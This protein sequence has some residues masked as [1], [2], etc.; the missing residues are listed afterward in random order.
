MSENDNIPDILL[1]NKSWGSCKFSFERLKEISICLSNLNI[2]IKLPIF[3]IL[4]QQEDLQKPFSRYKSILLNCILDCIRLALPIST[5]FFENV[6]LKNVFNSPNKHKSNLKQSN[7]EIISEI[8][9][10]GLIE[11]IKT[12]LEK[13]KTI[14]SKINS[15]N[16]S[17]SKYIYSIE[18]ATEKNS[19][20]LIF[21]IE[22]I[23]ESIRK[24]QFLLIFT[25]L[26]DLFENSVIQ[27][28]I[29][30]IN[31]CK[32][33]ISS[34]LSY[35][36]TI[37]IKNELTLNF[38]LK[39]I[40]LFQSSKTT[41]I[42]DF[43]PHISGIL[44][45][46]GVSGISYITNTILTESIRFLRYKT[47]FSFDSK[48]L[49]GKGNDWWRDDSVLVPDLLRKSRYE[50]VKDIQ[51]II[52]DV[53]HLL[54]S[55]NEEYI[56]SVISQM[57]CE[58]QE[59]DDMLR[60]ETVKMVTKFIL[61]DIKS[62]YDT[63][64][65]G[66][67]IEHQ[68]NTEKES[69]LKNQLIEF[70]LS[71]SN[72]REDDIR[73]EVLEG[74][75]EAVNIF[76]EKSEFGYSCEKYIKFI[77]QQ[78]N[79]TCPNIRENMIKAVSVWLKNK[80]KQP[81]S[82]KL[83]D[84][85]IQYLLRHICDRNRN[86]RIYLIKHL[87]GYNEI[88]ELSR[89]LWLLWYVSFKQRDLQM[90]IIIEDILIEIN[91]LEAL[92]LYSPIKKTSETLYGVEKAE[93]KS[94]AT[95]YKIIKTFNYQR[96]TLLKSFRLFFCLLFL[97]QFHKNNNL[98]KYLESLKLEITTQIEHFFIENDK[99]SKNN[100][101]L[102]AKNM[103]TQIQ[104]SLISKDC[105]IKWAIILGMNI[106]NK[107]SQIENQSI[108]ESLIENVGL[109]QVEEF[110]KIIRYLSI[111]KFN[112]ENVNCK[113]LCTIFSPNFEITKDKLL[114]EDYTES[115]V[116]GLVTLILRLQFKYK[117]NLVNYILSN[118]ELNNLSGEEIVK[119][120]NGAINIFNQQ[121]IFKVYENFYFSSKNIFRKKLTR[122]LREINSMSDEMNEVFN[123]SSANNCFICDN[124]QG[125]HFIAEVIPENEMKI[126]VKDTIY[127]IFPKISISSIFC[128]YSDFQT[129]LDSNISRKKYKH[130]NTEKNWEIFI[131]RLQAEKIA[132]YE[133]LETNDADQILNKLICLIEET[134]M[135]SE[136]KD[137]RY[138]L[139]TKLIGI[140]CLLFFKIKTVDE[141]L[142]SKFF[143]IYYNFN[144]L[145]KP[146]MEFNLNKPS[147][148]RLYSE[149]KLFYIYFTHKIEPSSHGSIGVNLSSFEE[150]IFVFNLYFYFELTNYICLSE[151]KNFFRKNHLRLFELCQEFC[152]NRPDCLLLLMNSRILNPDKNENIHNILST[153]L[154]RSLGISFIPIL[155][156]KLSEEL[157]SQTN[158]KEI[159]KTIER[160]I[161][162]FFGSVI[163]SKMIKYD[164]L[165]CILDCIISVFLYYTSKI[166][167]FNLESINCS[168]HYFVKIIYDQ[169]FE[170]L[171][172]NK[173]VSEQLKTIGIYC[174]ELLEEIGL[175]YN[176][177]PDNENNS[178]INDFQISDICKGVQFHI[179][180]F[181]AS[182]DDKEVFTQENTDTFGNWNYIKSTRK[183]KIPSYL[184]S[185]VETKSKI[186]N[187]FNFKWNIP[188]KNQCRTIQGKEIRKIFPNKV[189]KLADSNIRIDY[190][191]YNDQNLVR[192]D[193]K[194]DSDSSNLS[195]NSG[196]ENWIG[197]VSFKIGTLKELRRSNR[198]KSH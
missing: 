171:K 40:N 43:F 154:G 30:M 179:S 71:R 69:K 36:G 145:Y 108:I 110:K 120:I 157:E 16:K 142:F 61:L 33:A 68:I 62:E 133:S 55:I 189:R 85:S 99:N 123:R 78:K 103:L 191:N 75:V 149:N 175:K 152:N 31:I 159:E 95:I 37:S 155:S 54:G 52:I 74:V 104:N 6:K 38:L 174:T 135:N 22:N 168:I 172:N 100:A 128:S 72:D 9:L 7:A 124:Y 32:Y 29:E 180:Y 94:N 3:E 14:D 139:L 161:N 187:K 12:I 116:D 109:D 185:R 87:K 114:T 117:V 132:Q 64:F 119:L 194:Y 156:Q 163:Y 112:P 153:A 97:V 57:I 27:N 125:N 66:S 140:G 28:N 134:L 164:Q 181:F 13:Y 88:P 65:Q 138:I 183:F 92:E 196:D 105:F 25:M 177:L 2:N 42:A 73:T 76:L 126:V 90:R 192:N 188:K 197:N 58:L 193:D 137:D 173:N 11:H 113:V 24:E 130:L 178:E 147:S 39:L 70:W 165:Y 10:C 96:L 148:T 166:N 26:L 141:T 111:F 158:F 82:N 89:N 131:L 195:E 5:D 102:I 81:N 80:K 4:I 19:K 20:L 136:F 83:I 182:N 167:H 176:C 53:I 184:F 67:K 91:Q 1:T 162:I 35:S 93:N 46:V 118:P 190:R 47:K 121:E 107:D 127:Q 56:Q 160:T 186:D 34:I 50:K 8:I 15:S 17:W 198:L 45:N 21:L 115:F 41:K 143:D 106:W 129:Y 18:R 77:I 44:S 101:I 144:K 151:L 84:D 170:K 49:K 23:H 122:Y 86:I 79:I 48:G 51:T 63:T 146:N 60:F 98:S 59:T 169:L 150:N